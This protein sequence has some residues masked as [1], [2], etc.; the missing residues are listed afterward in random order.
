MND[1]SL[2]FAP[3]NAND[4]RL[5]PNSMFSNQHKIISCQRRGFA[6]PSRAQRELPKQLATPEEPTKRG[7]GGW[8]L[9]GR[10]S[11][12]RE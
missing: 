1:F 8:G 4:G 9:A 6:R 2:R 11:N 7:L 5:F 12:A 3:L 10:Q